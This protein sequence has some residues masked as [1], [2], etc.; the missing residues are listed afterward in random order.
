[1]RIRAAGNDPKAFLFQARGQRLGIGDHPL[2]IGDKFRRHRFQ[3]TDRLGCNHV[4]QGPAL[5]S[6]EHYFVDG[7]R[8]LGARKDHAGARAAQRLVRGGSDDVGVL[9]GVRIQ[10]RRHQTGEVRHVHQENRADGI[11]DLAEALEIDD[12]RVGAAACDDHFWT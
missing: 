7:G 6:G 4:H 10:S 3:E 12:A 2:L 9:A 5:R 1:V 8:I 11:G